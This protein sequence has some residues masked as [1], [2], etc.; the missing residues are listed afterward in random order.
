MLNSTSCNFQDE[1]TNITQLSVECQSLIK[2][3][4][5]QNLL[6]IAETNYTLSVLA[7]D[8]FRQKYLNCTVSIDN[9]RSLSSSK[10]NAV[11]EFNQFPVLMDEST[12]LVYGLNV[13][14]RF[15]K[16]FGPII[17]RLTIQS[18]RFWV[19]EEQTI[20]GFVNEYCSQSLVK[21]NLQVTSHD[22]MRKLAGP[23]ENVDELTVN[24]VVSDIDEITTHNYEK[25]NQIFP[26]VQNLSLSLN[27]NTKTD[28]VGT[29]PKLRYLS[30]KGDTSRP[31]SV[32]ADTTYTER[33]LDQ[34]PQIK[35][36]K[37]VFYPPDFVRMVKLYLPKLEQ[38][39]LGFFD[40]GNDRIQ[41]DHVKTFELLS[42]DYGSP[43]KILFKNLEELRMW[44]SSRYAQ[45]WIDFFIMNPHLKRVYVEDFGDNQS[46]L[47]LQSL[48]TQIKDI[49]DITILSTKTI[50]FE[51]IVKFIE[52][53]KQ[54]K[55]FKYGSKNY[56]QHNAEFL[57]K[58]FEK[59]WNISEFNGYYGGLM[60]ER[61]QLK[62]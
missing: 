34:N 61:K 43:A 24:V 60:F 59:N 26:N 29:L 41:F 45:E 17:Q 16:H 7:A 38:L 46:T 27:S 33:L 18:K 54:L 21:L 20:M 37:L 12:I 8:V 47:D 39:S 11:Q 9:D 55:R 23:F 31:D 22:T 44:Y 1:K 5:V 14:L 6:E 56:D 10:S 51:V 25:L 30:L 62:V 53:H 49:E 40:L 15:L 3:L 52:T 19:K 32:R 13:S 57:K 35:S 28:F 50:K 48:I 2:S 42:G 58:E 4:D 36:L